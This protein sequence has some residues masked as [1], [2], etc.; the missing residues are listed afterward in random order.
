MFE[1]LAENIKNLWKLKPSEE[2]LLYKKIQD[3]NNFIRHKTLRADMRLLSEVLEFY[4]WQL[5]EEDIKKHLGMDDQ[6]FLIFKKEGAFKLG[7]QR[8]EEMKAS[9]DRAKETSSLWN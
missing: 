1:S 7:L 5:H 4:L 3:E 8:I 6:E 9:F 2:E